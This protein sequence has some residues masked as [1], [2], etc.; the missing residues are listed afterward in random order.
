MGVVVGVNDHSMQYTPA[1]KLV[2]IEIINL[3]LLGLSLLYSS[4]KHSAK[5]V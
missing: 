2:N 3:K 5:P 4:L 1:A